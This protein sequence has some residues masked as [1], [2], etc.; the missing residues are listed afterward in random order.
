MSLDQVFHLHTAP[1]VNTTE[2]KVYC[3]CYYSLGPI[4]G[5]LNR[6]FFLAFTFT[7]HL[8][9]YGPLVWFLVAFSSISGFR[10]PSI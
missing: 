4:E 9:D 3:R 7:A 1:T 2:K 10:V 8:C 6:D 5:G